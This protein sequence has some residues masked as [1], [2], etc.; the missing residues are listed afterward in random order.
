MNPETLISVSD[1]SKKLKASSRTVRYFCDAGYI[2]HV[3]RNRRYQRL[4]T[5]AQ[6]ELLTIL[7][8][9]KQAGFRKSEIKRYAKLARQGHSTAAQCLAVLTTRKH[10][11]W[12]EIK[13]RQAAIDFIERQEEL[14]AA[15]GSASSD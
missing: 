8:K 12:Q 6:F 2:P 4:L 1:A 7:V 11:L 10:Q 15:S 3:K 9:M 13:A 5:P 14:A